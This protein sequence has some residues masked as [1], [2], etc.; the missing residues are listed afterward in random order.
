MKV[1]ITG[2]AGFIGSNLSKYFLESERFEEIRVID[3]LSTGSRSNLTGLDV[4]F[5]EASILED[6][7]LNK[8]A[9]NVDTIVHLGAIPSVPRSIANPMRSHEANITGTLMVLEAARRQ[10]VQQ[11]IVASSSSVYGANPK[12]PKREDDWTRPMSPY[13]V[14]KLAT[15]GY[16][17]GYQASYGLKAL[18]FRFFN[19]YGP[20]QAA[21]HDYAAVIPKFIHAA[22]S[23]EPAEVYGDG[24]QS[25]DFTYVDTVCQVI[26]D[27][28][29]NGKSSEAPVN[30]AFN[31]HTT[32]L[33][34]L[35][36]IEELV[37]HPVKR[38]H[39][40]PRRGDVK[41]SQADPTAILEMFPDAHPIDLSTGLTNTINWFK[42]QF[43]YK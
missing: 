2:G 21:N 10:N 16:A 17:L 43:E 11:V 40:E 37:G 18:A 1:L 3:N 8:A 6:A 7:A 29:L 20:G 4:E 34:L 5:I 14:T 38:I 19:V 9:K 42:G 23:G 22:L 36:M 25:R 24:H 30:L 13:A 33:E 41:A 35:K 31:T 32:L 28:V 26:M 39:Y 12:L 15:E 27:A